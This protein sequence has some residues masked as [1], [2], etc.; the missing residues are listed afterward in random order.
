MSAE[1][2]ELVATY[3]GVHGKT[4]D[5]YGCWGKDTPEDKFEFFDLFITEGRLARC[6]N[7]GEPFFEMPTREEVKD[8][9]LDNYNIL[10]KGE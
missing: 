9:V 6:I 10:F 8:F 2:N 7:E 1:G 4:I 3:Y 5:I